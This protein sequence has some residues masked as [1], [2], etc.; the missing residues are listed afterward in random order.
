MAL[1][2][3]SS[4]V[5]F[6]L[7][8]HLAGLPAICYIAI[9]TQNPH[10]VQ[11]VVLVLALGYLSCVHIYR[12]LYDYTSYTLDITAPLMVIT[13]KVISLAYSIHDGSSRDELELTPLQRHQAVKKIP[14]VLEFF[15]FIFHFQALLVGPVI[16][17]R[18]YIE[19]IYETGF[20]DGEKFS[21]FYHDSL[22]NTDQ[23]ILEPSPIPVV[24]KKIISSII[25]A[26]LFIS[27]LPV[28]PIQKV[29]DDDFLQSS[30]LY[31]IMYLIIS[32]TIVRFKYYY[33][34]LFADAVCNNSGLGF[35]GIDADG[36]PHWDKFSNIDIFK[37]EL[38]TN[39]RE[40]IE[41]WNKGTNRWLRM[42]VYER[43]SKYQTIMTFFLSA[44]WHGF[45]PGYYLT[46]AGGALFTFS[47]RA[48]RQTL[49]PYFLGSK[50]LKI[51]YKVLTF[52]TTR[53]VMAYLTFS[54][55]LLEF[56]PSIRVYLSMYLIP[57]LLGLT[58][59][60]LLPLLPIGKLKNTQY[61]LRN[62]SNDIK[63]EQNI[64]NEL[65]INNNGFT[66]EAK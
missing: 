29:K 8:V 32:T 1:L 4:W 40:S 10:I 9:R 18:D 61:Q 13:Q 55:V 42:V 45:Y 7:A 16:F 35:N 38:S 33:A 56:T 27:L 22:N 30:T 64:N 20:K 52:I 34:W 31:K 6:A 2:L 3:V 23:M 51:I 44:L 49:R 28:F 50:I 58:A 63:N 12:Q 14:T 48:I 19:F 25:C 36:K 59:I 43:T 11:R 37:F 66:K 15:G 39:L 60:F 21:N 65:K 57:H 41:A 5:T 24:V 26:I 62:L 47:G 46:F 17:Y 54:F 53:I